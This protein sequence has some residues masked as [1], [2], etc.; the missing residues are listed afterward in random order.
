MNDLI[1]SM[2]SAA[3]G[4]MGQSGIGTGWSGVGEALGTMLGGGRNPEAYYKG[5]DNGLSLVKKRLE[6]RKLRDEAMARDSLYEK[7]SQVMDPKQAEAAVALAI[8][9]TGTDFAGAM[10]GLERNQTI[11]MRERA[12]SAPSIAAQNDVLAVIDGKPRDLTQINAGTA[13]DP[14]R[15]PENQTMV[16]TP[17]AAADNVRQMMQ[18]ESVVRRND[19]AAAA[20][21][22]RANA[23]R[24]VRDP[25]AEHA[26]KSRI[27]AIVADYKTRM[28]ETTDPATIARLE[29]ERD[30][31]ILAIQNEAMPAA[32]GAAAANA[33]AEAKAAA[34]SMR[35]M[36]V[37]VSDAQ[38][39][40]MERQIRET[41]DFRLTTPVAPNDGTR[42]PEVV[43]PASGR[44]VASPTRA[45]KPAP[46]A[47]PAPSANAMP[48]R[49]DYVN[50]G[51][52]DIPQSDGGLPGV[53]L[54]KLREGVITTF[55]NGQ[56]W[57]KRNGKPVRVK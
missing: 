1:A 16:I 45:P 46:A 48:P 55:A 39:A 27:N 25:V 19:A 32:N 36:G 4:S 53:A 33:A 14:T 44:P 49:Y 31:K 15:T 29:K 47:R 42:P 7:L 43:D 23:T 9:G 26:V 35:A 5:A 8:S 50:G 12:L 40:D 57:T 21:T 20:S 38:Q 18:A 10:S 34:D 3:A 6:A 52:R 2:S 51:W 22:T 11:G 24:P 28:D 56:Q 54:E 13:Y 17:D 41:G 30:S 37:P